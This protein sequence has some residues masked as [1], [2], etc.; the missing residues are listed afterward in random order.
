MFCSL[1]SI[2]CQNKGIYEKY[3]PLL[4]VPCVVGDSSQPHTFLVASLASLF[5]RNLAVI[6]TAS[7]NLPPFF[8]SRTSLMICTSEQDFVNF[9]LSEAS[10]VGLHCISR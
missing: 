8:R 9:N 1:V 7:V 4:F 5:V 3:T 2:A 6:L 10:C